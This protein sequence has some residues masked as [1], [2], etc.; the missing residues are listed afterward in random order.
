MGFWHFEPLIL[1][2]NSLLM[3]S[4]ACYALVGSIG[5][6]L[7]GGRDVAIGP[8]VIYAAVVLV[9]T[10]TVGLVE[11]RANKRL[12]SALVAMDVKGWLMAGGVTSA[13]LIAFL[14]AFVLQQ[15]SASWLVPYVDPGVLIV[16]AL[17]LIPVPIPI[18]RKA[19]AE[20]ALITPADLMAKAQR[21][22]SDTAKE[23]QLIDY[24]IWASRQGRSDV[25]ELDFQAAADEHRPLVEWDRIRM[26]VERALGGEDRNHWIA[27]RFTTKDLAEAAD[28]I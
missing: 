23:H 4:I 13:L 21:V 1:A 22:A 15:T 10:I 11:H 9:L 8:A 25:V 17:V 20:L 18:L 24:R 19:I 6:I 7:E 2:V 16:V 5:A 14:V 28:R 27:V 26:E 12:N 3:I